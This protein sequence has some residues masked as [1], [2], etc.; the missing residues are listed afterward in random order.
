MV[1]QVGYSRMLAAE[2]I[3]QAVVDNSYQPGFG[4]QTIVRLLE[5]PSMMLL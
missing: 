2:I 4:Y 3:P 1:R 5:L